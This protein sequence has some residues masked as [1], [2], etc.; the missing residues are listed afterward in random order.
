MSAS[1]PSVLFREGGPRDLRPAFELAQLALR[2]LRGRM[3]PVPGQ[4]PP[5]HGLDELWA[6][7]RSLHEFIA[8][9]DG[10]FWLCEGGEGIVGFARVVR[11]DDMEQ[12]SELFVHPAHQ[13]NGIGKGLLEHCWPEPPTPELG[14]VVVATGAPADLSLYTAFGVMPADGRLSLVQRTERYLEHRLRERDATEPG[15]H[16]L[17]PGRALAEWRRLEPAVV[18]HRRP[19]LQEFFARERTCLACLDGEGRATALCW[20]SPQGELGPGIAG[21]AE[22]LVPV[23]LTALD[24]VAKTHEP[25][26]LTVSVVATSWWL[27]QRLRRLGFRVSWP[28]W[29]LCSVPLP[30][31]HRYL[32]VDPALFL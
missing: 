24:R 18:G 8:A 31:L 1:A 30:E 16:V 32:P 20:V 5:S 26:E 4:A 21:S 15:V 10:Q 27:L 25:E 2:E 12:L 9:Q 28:G 17:E 11:F 19:Q 7:R 6:R 29:I 13:G 14:R 22:E 23:V 3:G